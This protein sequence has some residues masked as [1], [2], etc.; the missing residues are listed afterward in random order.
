MRGIANTAMGGAYAAAC[1]LTSDELAE[2]RRIV[3]VG[4]CHVPNQTVA[5]RLA[6]FLLVRPALNAAT[7]SAWVA[8]PWGQLVAQAA[9]EGAQ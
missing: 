2:L 5:E 1:R 8:E 7:R 4:C 3:H 6:E 9:K